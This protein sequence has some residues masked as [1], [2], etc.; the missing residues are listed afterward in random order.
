MKLEHI[1]EKSGIDPKMSPIVIH[2]IHYF[3]FIHK[4]LILGIGTDPLFLKLFITP[5]SADQ[6]KKLFISFPDILKMHYNI[7]IEEHSIDICYDSK[8]FNYAVN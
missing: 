4:P 1:I 5:L 3:D 8:L 2:L 6:K 7:S